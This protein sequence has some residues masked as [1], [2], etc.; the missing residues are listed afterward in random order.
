MHPPKVY[1][2][3]LIEW[4]TGNARDLPWR[5]TRDPYRI[6]LSEII[7]QQTRVEQ[8]LPYYHRFAERFPDI[9]S[10]A[11]AEEQDVLRL[12]QGLGYYTRG[13]NLHRCAR[14]IIEHCS[15]RFPDTYD[16]LLKLPGVGPYTAAALA[17]FAFD[18]AE[19]VVDGNVLRFLSRLYGITQDTGLAAT[20]QK[21]ADLAG[22]MMPQDRPGIFNQ[23]LMEFGA[24]NCTPRAPRCANCVFSDSCRAFQD[25][26]QD[27][28]PVKSPAKYRRRRYFH[29]LVFK[30]GPLTAMTL[31]GRG[32]IWTGLYE[33]YLIE[34]DMV[35]S[36][37]KLLEQAK[38]VL[39]P[40]AFIRAGD[41]RRSRPHLLSHQSIHPCFMEIDLDPGIASSDILPGF[42]FYS[43]REIEQL[44]KPVLIE[45]YRLGKLI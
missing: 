8:G 45:R 14:H 42:L 20:R 30:A 4:Y 37:K 7:L 34:Q 29:Y 43:D 16:D 33:Y 6:W 18:R 38:A 40:A 27:R 28:L 15:G 21:I 11:M 9:L 22:E 12:W 3:R 10:L 2:E 41:L 25:G 19:P 17:S 44:P 5:H 31:R 24:L 23:A 1:G 26:M 35:L 32:D 13:R 36:R 39:P